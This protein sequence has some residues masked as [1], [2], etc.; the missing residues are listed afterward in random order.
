MPPNGKMSYAD[1]REQVRQELLKQANATN[2]EGKKSLLTE[3]WVESG[4][5][6]LDWIEENI[7]LENVEDFAWDTPEEM[8]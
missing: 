7:K 6:C 4:L 8:N 1:A 2:E 3:E 5:R